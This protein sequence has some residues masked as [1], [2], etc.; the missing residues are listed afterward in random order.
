VAPGAY[1]YLNTLA[2]DEDTVRRVFSASCST[3]AEGHA[4]DITARRIQGKCRAAEVGHEPSINEPLARQDTD[5][6]R[7]RVA[8]VR[9]VVEWAALSQ[10]YQL[11]TQAVVE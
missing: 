3:G 7:L 5:S 2:A 6:H 8:P 4:A 1:T 11:P 9:Y 10:L